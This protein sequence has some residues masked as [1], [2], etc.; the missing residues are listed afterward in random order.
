MYENIIIRFLF[1]LQ[2]KSITF[3]IMFIPIKSLNIVVSRQ[4]T[5]FLYQFKMS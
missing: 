5:L 3:H 1:K 2:I 4:E